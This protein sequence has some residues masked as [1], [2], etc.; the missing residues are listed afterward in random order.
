[1]WYNSG[2]LDIKV[3]TSENGPLFEAKKISLGLLINSQKMHA[4]YRE[5]RHLEVFTTA[6][7]RIES[8]LANPKFE[9][10]LTA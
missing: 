10:N 5:N 1:M 8:L 9:A 7:S 4:L 6:D 3:L 2:R